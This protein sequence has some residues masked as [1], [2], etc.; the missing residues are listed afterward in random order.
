MKNNHK[1][2]QCDSDFLDAEY[3]H[4]KT[5]DDFWYCLD[6]VPFTRY[7]YSELTN[8]NISNSMRFLESL[9]NV[10]IVNDASKFSN[11]T[12]NEASIAIPSKSCSKYYSVKDFKT[13]NISK[14][15]NIFHTNINGLESK[16]DN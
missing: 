4:L 2:I 8:I 14:N 13:L 16:L 1:A 9:P 3:E 10:E 15:I 12:S 7:D 11:V 6:N 5:D